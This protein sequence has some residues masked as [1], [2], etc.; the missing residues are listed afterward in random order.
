[1]NTCPII[2]GVN[3]YATFRR[4]IASHKEIAVRR[5]P[6]VRDH[7]SPLC[8]MMRNLDDSLRRACDP[9]FNS[10]E[11]FSLLADTAARALGLC[12][13]SQGGAR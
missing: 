12:P 13:A 5:Y 9:L 1:M 4:L 3:D 11:K 10:P 6:Q 7:G 8:R 2:P